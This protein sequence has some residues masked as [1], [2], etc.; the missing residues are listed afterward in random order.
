[1]PPRL[2][3]PNR[4]KNC[5]SGFYELDY[6]LLPRSIAW[7][8]LSESLSQNLNRAKVAIARSDSKTHSLTYI[9]LIYEKM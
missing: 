7:K 6:R 1:L 2:V 8:V 9:E 4:S 5:A 3:I